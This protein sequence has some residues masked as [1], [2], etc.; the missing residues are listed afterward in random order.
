MKDCKRM[1]L[2]VCTLLITLLL[3]GCSQ[4]SKPASSASTDEVTTDGESSSESYPNKFPDHPLADGLP[5]KFGEPPRTVVKLKPP[6]QLIDF[7]YFMD[8][9]TTFVHLRDA[10]GREAMFSLSQDMEPADIS[11]NTLFVGAE[12][13]D[14]KSARLPLTLAEARMLSDSL[15]LALKPLEPKRKAVL[16]AQKRSHRDIEFLQTF[17]MMT[18]L[19]KIKKFQLADVDQIEK[20]IREL[21]KVDIEALAKKFRSLQGSDRIAVWQQLEPAFIGEINA[22]PTIDAV[23]FI[24]NSL[25]EPDKIVEHFFPGK[26]SYIL[27][28]K[29]VSGTNFRTFVIFNLDDGS[30]VRSGMMNV[31]GD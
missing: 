3:A 29:D 24:K 18:K 30:R 4:S 11:L 2:K 31:M 25:G 15:Q 22:D 12:H 10:S 1:R 17:E 13:P 21:S 8:G 5:G 23:A 19:S 28:T 9:G 27:H 20:R 6:I 14:D 26:I 7:G 16:N